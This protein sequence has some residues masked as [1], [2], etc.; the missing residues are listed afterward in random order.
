MF[1]SKR[2]A[3]ALA[4]AA[5]L[6]LGACASTIAGTAAVPEIGEMSAMPQATTTTAAPA[7]TSSPVPTTTTTT[8]PPP[9]PP[10]SAA[11]PVLSAAELGV[12]FG[13]SGLVAREEAAQQTPVGTKFTC[14]YQQSGRTVARLS[15][16]YVRLGGALLP[17]L[18]KAAANQGAAVAEVHG[19]GEVA[20]TYHHPQQS[21]Q[22][23]L[24]TGK[25]HDPASF[26]VDLA[27]NSTNTGQVLSGLPDLANRVLGRL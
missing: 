21:T 15:V 9:P 18:V 1:S 27:V 13:V 10:I 4:V 16:N 24:V 11:C 2:L 17:S 20:F 12:K 26:V 14:S 3:A 6:A 25:R 23:G 8:T 19:V 22:I 5:P 7:T